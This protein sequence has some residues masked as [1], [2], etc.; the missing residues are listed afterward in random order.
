MG[1]SANPDHDITPATTGYD[2]G[3]PVQRWDGYFQDLDVSG[4][5]SVL[6]TSS[7]TAIPSYAFASL[8][9]AGTAGRLANVTNVTRGVWLDTGSQWASLSGEI[10]NVKVFGA[11]GDGTTDDTA[12]ILAAIASLAS[13][14]GTVYMPQ[15]VYLVTSTITLGTCQKLVGAGSGQPNGVPPYRGATTIISSYDGVVIQVGAAGA[16][17]DHAWLEGITVVGDTTSTSQ[18]LVVMGPSNPA[19][20]GSY[21]TV[22][23]VQTWI[24]GRDGIRVQNCQ[25]SL[26][27]YCR[28]DSSQRY[29]AYLTA[30]A[31]NFLTASSFRDCQFRVASRWGVFVDGLGGGTV[32]QIRFAG[33][34]I[35]GNNAS[36]PTPRSVADAGITATDKTLTSATA[37]FTSADVGKQVNIA[38]AGA[39]GT[40]LITFID[41]VTNSTTAEVGE[42]AGTTVAGVALVINGWGGFLSGNQ[43]MLL[44]GTWFEANVGAANGGNDILVTSGRVIDFGSVYVGGRT[45]GTNPGN[46]VLGAP[47]ANYAGFGVR[48]GIAPFVNAGDGSTSTPYVAAAYT[49]S[50]NPTVIKRGATSYTLS[51]G[52]GSP[53][54][55]G[56]THSSE[57]PLLTDASEFLLVNWGGA[58]LTQAVVG[59]DTAFRL[60]IVAGAAPG[61]NPTATLTFKDG[62]WTNTPFAVAVMNNGTTASELASPCFT[63]VSAT[64]VLVG[65][66][67]TPTA[68]RTYVFDVT[69]RSN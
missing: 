21:L 58:G 47:T 1:T 39:S 51:P 42:A 18:D 30:G 59:T 60:T 28:F 55:T 26:I 52:S 2:L 48:P 3:S 54:F 27:D 10:A 57:R 53:S 68:G 66:V 38:G 24:S 12:A 34:T 44:E 32:Q 23:D 69:V 43:E 46:I 63:G 36:N 65:W 5:L 29:A 13:N 31:G 49:S 45:A 35:Q 11:K 33:C 15:G 8:P 41:S 67:G 40:N 20:N 37:S 9:T 61:A 22:R 62:T 17:S 25:N 4:N 19:F 56:R 14:G 16:T 64:Q 6:G 7:L 50:A